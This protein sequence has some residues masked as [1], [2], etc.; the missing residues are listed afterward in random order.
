MAK[1]IKSRKK[2]I[3]IPLPYRTIFIVSL[4]VFITTLLCSALLSYLEKTTV[5]S[6]IAKR[7]VAV[8]TTDGLMGLIGEEVTIKPQQVVIYTVDYKN[9]SSNDLFITIK[10]TQREHDYSKKWCNG[11]AC[12]LGAWTGTAYSEKKQV[13]KGESVQFVVPVT[14]TGKTPTGSVELEA[15]KTIQD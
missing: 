2:T 1:T 7:T 12:D 13:K 6:S 11:P 3:A 15:F 5:F 10:A 9:A 4:S 8:Q 14:P